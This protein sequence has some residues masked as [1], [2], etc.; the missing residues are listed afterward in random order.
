[1]LTLFAAVFANISG[2]LRT[3]GCGVTLLIA[4]TTGALENAR[5]RAFGFVVAFFTAVETGPAT[6]TAASTWLWAFA[7]EVTRLATAVYRGKHKSST[8]DIFLNLLAARVVTSPTSEITSIA[9][10]SEITL[11]F[12]RS[13]VLGWARSTPVVGISS[14]IGWLSVPISHL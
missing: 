9:S 1:L 12:Q 13:K 11:L 6:A 3:L 8:R 2:L 10:I 4:N 7:S 5:I 14:S